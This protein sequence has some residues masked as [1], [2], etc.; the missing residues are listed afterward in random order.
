MH[1]QQRIQACYP[2]VAP[3][4]SVMQDSLVGWE[5]LYP[6]NEVKHNMMNYNSEEPAGLINPPSPKLSNST[7]R[8]AN[9]LKAVSQFKN[10]G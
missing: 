6:S 9:A 8:N 4:K 10:T 3:T 5:Q 1:S 2:Q 7:S